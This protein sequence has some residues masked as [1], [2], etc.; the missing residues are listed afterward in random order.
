MT[1]TTDRAAAP[2]LRSRLPGLLSLALA[3]G[4]AVTTEMLPVGLLPQIGA[5]FSTSESITG[6]LVTL[7]AVM[8][9]TLAVPLTIAT[10]RFGRRPLLLMTVLGYVVSNALVAA[11]PTFEVVAAGRAIGGLTHALFFSLTIGYVPR[12]VAQSDVGRALA[13][14]S[15]A[16]SA[17][18][19]LGMPLSTS[20]GT[21][22]GW[23]MSFTVL[24]VLSCLTF[25]AVYKLLPRVDYTPHKHRR[26]QKGR[27]A[28][29]AVCAS[30]L[31]T[32][33]GHFTAYTFISVLLLAGGVSPAF[34]GPI[35][36]AC[37]ACGLIGL[38]WVGRNLDRS[39]RRTA[40]VALGGVI[41]AVVA[42]GISWPML[43][44][45]LAATALWSAAF[46]GIPSIYQAAAVRT[47]AL[48]PEQAGAWVN[49]TA[50]VG[51]A[52]GAAIGAA[53]LPTAGLMSLPW[54]AAILAGLGLA[55]ALMARKA[56]PQKV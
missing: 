40:A 37:G 24:A 13:I 33:L 55:V 39:P 52:G 27:G 3:S 23:R 45:V 7:Y 26:N 34:L 54:V 36:L 42:L 2:G 31:L 43:A 10:T 51:I 56:F 21:A 1:L 46:G 14:V 47:H 49:S 28:L 19:V 53:L 5:T 48:P 15:G 35:L 25:I 17:G 22:A 30:N 44:A 32:F 20:L 6:L 12:L 9:A 38:W 16:A 11:A 8:V 41:V 18:F 29:V 4:L 50:N